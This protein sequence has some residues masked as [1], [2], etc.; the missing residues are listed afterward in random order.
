[1]KNSTLSSKVH[2]MEIC[3]LIPAAGKGSRFG[4]PKVDALYNG[5]TFSEM[6]IKTLKEAGIKTYYI[7]RDIETPDM[8]ATLYNGWQQVCREGRHPD[9]WLIWPVDHPLVK[10]ET[11]VLMVDAF[12]DNSNS[13]IIPCYNNRNGHPVLLPGSFVFA[14]KADA[15]GLKGAILKSD[16]PRLYIEVDDA[17]ILANLNTPE[18]ALY[19]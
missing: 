19:A 18:E 14:K 11:I 9:G 8:S 13:V 10:K 16:F 15:A 17:G 4:Q 5:F 7:I 1:L 12:A 2:K 6:I 3:A